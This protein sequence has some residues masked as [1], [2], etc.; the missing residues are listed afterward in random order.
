MGAIAWVLTGR[1]SK[2]HSCCH[3]HIRN[4]A[5]SGNYNSSTSILS[6]CIC[7]VRSWRKKPV[8]HARRRALQSSFHP[9]IVAPVL[10]LCITCYGSIL[11]AEERADKV[12]V[13][14]LSSQ[15]WFLPVTASF[16]PI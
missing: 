3:R 12:P 9:H 1:K 10:S 6:M 11:T 5:V 4:I 7:G 8:T 15:A 14:H 16:E 13:L 2:L